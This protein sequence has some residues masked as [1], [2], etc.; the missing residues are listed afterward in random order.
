MLRA[1]TR[2]PLLGKPVLHRDYNTTSKDVSYVGEAP[3]Q[4]V[5]RALKMMDDLFMIPAM[6]VA[7][8]IRDEPDRTTCDDVLLLK[9]AVKALQAKLAL[10]TS[11][12]SLHRV[13]TSGY[14]KIC[15]SPR[16][17]G[18]E[19]RLWM[20]A[21]AS[22]WSDSLKSTC[23]QSTTSSLTRLT[24]NRTTIESLGRWFDLVAESPEDYLRATRIYLNE[25]LDD[26]GLKKAELLR[27][28]EEESATGADMSGQLCY[29][30]TSSSIAYWKL[31][32]DSSTTSGQSG[33]KAVKIFDDSS[34]EFV[35]RKNC[36]GAGGNCYHCVIRN[37]QEAIVEVISSAKQQGVS[38][39]N[40]R[41]TLSSG[42]P[43]PFPL[44]RYCL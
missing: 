37:L 35:C 32:K 41:S 9:H 23:G 13:A 3:L 6:E 22:W 26:K 8:A 29:R 10:D 12:S 33:S 36:T 5:Y 15:R 21:F 1:L 42:R 39:A 40:S 17:R 44:P 38:L 7:K 4:T 20:I 30:N 14:G 43:L 31:V 2:S 28:R 19:L 25:R 24:I 27:K 34:E 18:Q 16:A 11:R